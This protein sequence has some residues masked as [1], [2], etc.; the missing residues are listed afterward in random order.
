[1][2]PVKS[3]QAFPQPTKIL[4]GRILHIARDGSLIASRG[5]T[6]L[7]SLDQGDSFARFARAEVT[8]GERW[9]ARSSP[10]ARLFRLGFQ[11]LV[12]LSD[13]TLLGTVLRRLVRG[14]PSEPRLKTCFVVPRGSRPLSLGVG[15]GDFVAF[16][17]YFR[18]PRRLEVHIFGSADRG[19]TWEVLYTFPPGTIRHVHNVLWDPLRH[20]YL[21]LTGDQGPECKILFTREFRLFDTLME[22][23]Q[24]ARAVVAIPHR[25]GLFLPMDSPLEPN[26]VN[27][28]HNDGR[29]ERLFPLDGSC[30]SALR[31]GER[32]FYSTAVEPSR[33][34]RSR[35]CTIVMS[36]DRY[37]ADTVFRCAKDRYPWAFQYGNLFFPTAAEV[38]SNLFATA[39]GLQGAGLS[40][41]RWALP[42]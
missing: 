8:A 21:V 4:D 19:A 1:M 30:F 2:T 29:L 16:G 32:V 10:L 23:D 9:L 20:G 40:A 36:T 37:S 41:L 3:R 18:N 13:G 12:A 7:R 22:G 14:A 33:V 17:E 31:M 24:R 25:E 27:F 42:T 5:Y 38:P 6:L 34:N 15:P 28:L 35:E 39:V 26:Y 11:S